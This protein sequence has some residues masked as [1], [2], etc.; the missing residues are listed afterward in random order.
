MESVLKPKLNDDLK[1]ALRSGDKL[2][3]SVLR[4]LL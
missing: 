4:M 1:N 2:V 3:C